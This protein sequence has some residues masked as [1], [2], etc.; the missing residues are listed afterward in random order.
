M[1]VKLDGW[2]FLKSLD[3]LWQ[4]LENWKIIIENILRQETD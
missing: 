4:R 3:S 2:T 1:C